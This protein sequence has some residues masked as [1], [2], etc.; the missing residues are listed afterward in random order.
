MGGNH[1]MHADVRFIANTNKNLRM[2]AEEGRFRPDLLYRLEVISVTLPP[3]RDRKEDI[4][5]LVEH[6]IEQFNRNSKRGIRGVDSRTM[7]ALLRYHW[8]GNVRELGHCIERAAVMA[9]G[10][11]LH[12]SDLALFPLPMGAATQSAAPASGVRLRTLKEAEHDLILK[13][14]QGVRGNQ[15]QTAALLGISLRGLVYKL[16]KLRQA[17]VPFHGGVGAVSPP[18][19]LCV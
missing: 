19:G 4:P 9:D 12:V 18:R 8:P 6:F 13:T 3:L 15:T 1:P 5:L 17:A 10:D 14:L 7:E 11:V 2:M 16:R